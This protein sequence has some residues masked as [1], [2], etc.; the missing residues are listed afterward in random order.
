MNRD[1]LG[2]DDKEPVRPQADHIHFIT[3]GEFQN[4][5]DDVKDSNKKLDVVLFYGH[6]ILVLV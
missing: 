1:I 4:L 3:R 5:H 2:G 6:T